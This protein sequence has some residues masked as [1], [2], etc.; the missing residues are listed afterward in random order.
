MQTLRSPHTKHS[1]CVAK[2]AL[3]V[4]GHGNLPSTVPRLARFALKEC[5]YGDT[6]HLPDQSNQE[7]H[8][9]TSHCMFRQLSDMSRPQDGCNRKTCHLSCQHFTSCVTSGTSLEQG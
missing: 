8:L 1:D 6:C 9:Q 2:T 5:C 7:T 4:P 3:A